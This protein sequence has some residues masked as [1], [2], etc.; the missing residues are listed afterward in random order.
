MKNVFKPPRPATRLVSRLFLSAA[1]LCG[2]TACESVSLRQAYVI[3]ILG[4]QVLTSAK[5]VFLGDAD[6]IYDDRYYHPPEIWA[7][8]KYVDGSIR[9]QWI[10]RNS[11]KEQLALLDAGLFPERVPSSA[12]V[13]A[14]AKR[15]AFAQST[16]TEIH[17][18]SV[19]SAFVRNGVT[20]IPYPNP[21]KPHRPAPASDR[22]R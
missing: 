5:P 6:S 11:R 21:K 1:V 4:G 17:I 19:N 12:I 15:V 16:P 13:V 20:L 3:P 10:S 7:Y 8:E 18:D 22:V 2:S 9:V 14:N